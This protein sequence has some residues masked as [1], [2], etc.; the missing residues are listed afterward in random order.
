MRISISEIS[1]LKFKMSNGTFKY[2]DV[3]KVKDELDKVKDLVR[4]YSFI[5]QR[6]EGR[7]SSC[8]LPT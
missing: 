2:L 5:L 4:T 1:G 7:N 3:S 8:T 6:R